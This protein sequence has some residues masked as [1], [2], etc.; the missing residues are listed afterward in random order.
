MVRMQGNKCFLAGL[1]FATALTV[2]WPA[3]PSRAATATATMAVSATVL[4]TCLITA[5][6]LPFGNYTGVLTNVSTS[7]VV[8]CT[9]GTTYNVGLDPGQAT[10]ATTTTRKMKGT[11]GGLLSYSLYQ[12]SG[13]STNWGNVVGTDTKSGT[14]SG[15]AQTLTVYGQVTANQY[16]APDAYSDLITA[17]ITY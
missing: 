1:V 2:G 3:L 9:T 11:L 8:T 17:T 7:V 5:T 4:S 15:V 13:H 14:G 10:G 6:A 16:V 12:D